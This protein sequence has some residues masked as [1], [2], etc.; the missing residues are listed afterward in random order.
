MARTPRR[1]HISKRDVV[2]VLDAIVD[3]K[4]PYQARQ[5]QSYLKRF[6]KWCHGRDLIEANPI[7]AMEMLGKAKSR[8]RVLTDAELVKVWLAANSGPHHAVVRLLILTGTRREE[9][10]KLRWSEIDDDVLRLG[11]DRMKMDEKHVV[12]LSA[13]ALEVLRGIPRNGEFVFTLDG[14]KPLPNTWNRAKAK[15]DKACGVTDWQIR[16]L[17]RTV[18]TGMNEVGVEPHI[19]EAVLAH[20]VKGIAGVYNRA[21]YEAAKRKALEAWGD[22]V[23]K[24]VRS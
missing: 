20:K 2:A 3:R 24:L 6:F 19:V 22:H 5:T 11:G 15:L 14:V 12:H 1:Y 16:D 21:K 13:P 4:A 18:D 8:D 17:R 9:I 23:A 7:A 10:A